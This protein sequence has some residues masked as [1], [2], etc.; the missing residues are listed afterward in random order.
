LKTVSRDDDDSQDDRFSEISGSPQSSIDSKESGAAETD[1]DQSSVLGQHPSMHETSQE[2]TPAP[3]SG[4]SSKA[5]KE[6]GVSTDQV[7][8]E[9]DD[10]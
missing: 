10:E 6:N 4:M 5:F 8:N 7:S 2:D 1:N 3:N 9:L